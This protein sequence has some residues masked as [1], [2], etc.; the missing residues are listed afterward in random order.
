MA[1]GMLRKLIV[2]ILRNTFTD[3]A[4]LEFG[5][6]AAHPK[7]RTARWSACIKGLLVQV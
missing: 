1:L 7:H 6:D 5:K 3:H 4:A 2:T